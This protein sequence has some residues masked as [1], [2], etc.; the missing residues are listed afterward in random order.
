MDPLIRG[1]VDKYVEILYRR[2]EIHSF[3]LFSHCIVGGECGQNSLPSFDD[4]NYGLCHNINSHRQCIFSNFI[5]SNND[6]KCSCQ[7]PSYIKIIHKLL[8]FLIIL[9]I[10]FFIVNIIRI[11]R[12]QCNIYCLNDSLFRLISLLSSLFSVLFL[13][14]III[15]YNGNRSIES[16]E[17]FESMRQ[18]YSHIQIYTFTK[19]LELI[20]QQIENSLDIHIGVSYVCILTVLILKIMSF[21]TSVTVEIKIVSTSS[22]S[23]FSEDDE[24]KP[25]QYSNHINNNNN[26]NN[27]HHHHHTLIQ[28][29]PL[30]RFIPSEQIRFVRQTKV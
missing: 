2:D 5:L 13:I 1:E 18:H 24:K 11:T 15:Q 7:P 10:L 26:N 14:I 12:Y 22:S 20:I 29:I 19:D 28:P 30:E 9:E 4:K 21:L 16:L 27:H 17:F 8:I 25:Y 3:G 6:I 23:T